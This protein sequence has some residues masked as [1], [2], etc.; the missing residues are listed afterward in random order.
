M[1]AGRLRLLGVALAMAL[2]MA[3]PVSTQD[4]TMSFFITS[5]GPGDGANLGGLEAPTRTARRWPRRPW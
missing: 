4:A 1:H 3:Y 5:A 2:A